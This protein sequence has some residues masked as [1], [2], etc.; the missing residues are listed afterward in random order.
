MSR[1]CQVTGKKTTTG[2]N[3]SHSQRKTKRTFKPN[4]QTKRIFDEQAGRFVKVKVSTKG[5]KILQKKG[6]A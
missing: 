1:V 4:I 2:H 6:L 3:V 5:L